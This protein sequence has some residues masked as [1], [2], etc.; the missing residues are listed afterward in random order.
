MEV[1]V[2]GISP[3]CHRVRAKISVMRVGMTLPV[4]EPRVSTSTLRRWAAAVDDGPFS[5]LC[6]GERIAFANPD[7]LTLLGALS[8]W[9][10]RVRLVATV[11]VPQ[12]HDPVLLAK[13][14]ATADQP[15]GGRL[16]VGLGADG[17][18]AGSSAAVSDQ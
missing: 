4:M 15:C 16:P 14:L 3:W 11:V 5:S 17:R 9:T 2:I 13:A 8:A 7:S 1:L 18:Q 6:W 10:D 12:L